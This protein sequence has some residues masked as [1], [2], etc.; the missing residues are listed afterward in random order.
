MK[1]SDRASPYFGFHGTKRQSFA[2]LR[3]Y[4]TE[5]Y[6]FVVFWLLKYRVTEL[7]FEF[8]SRGKVTELCFEFVSRGKLSETYFVVNDQSK[9]IWNA[10]QRIKPGSTLPRDPKTSSGALQELNKAFAFW[11]Y[12]F[13][14]R[15]AHLD[16]PNSISP[17]QATFW[18]THAATS[19]FAA[20]SQQA[21]LHCTHAATSQQAW[22]HCKAEPSK[23][24]LRQLT[25]LGQTAR[26]RTKSIGV[27]PSSVSSL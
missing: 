4:E 15:E 7:R 21:W 6:S 9:A 3:F 16:K 18:R 25:K 24:Y 10:R 19:L 27:R 17:G 11:R 23:F 13:L 14:Q 1:Q 2:V 5:W 26:E 20:T 12:Q 8:V 22:L